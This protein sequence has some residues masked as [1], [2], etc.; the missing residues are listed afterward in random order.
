MTIVE[1]PAVRAILL[2]PQLEVLLMRIRLP[3]R[4][5]AI[6]ITPGGGLS[7]GET[8]EH[9]LQRELREEL[10][11]DD[12]QLGPL[13]WLRE[14]TFTVDGTRYRQHERFYVVNVEKFA[15]QM[16][17][18]LES[19]VLE[20]FRW[21][22]ASELFDIPESVVPRSLAQIVAGYLEHGAPAEPLELEVV[23]DQD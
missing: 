20:R 23:I 7:A 18:E 6:W 12:Y 19:R 2:T 14:H 22:H 1:R 16:S 9:C 13:V 21:W 10:G 3:G 17:D 15:P 4:S 11:L 8:P 5:D